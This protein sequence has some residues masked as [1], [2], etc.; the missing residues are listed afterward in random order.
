VKTIVTVFR[1]P[2]GGAAAVA[3]GAPQNPHSRKRSGFS[4]PQEEQIATR[5]V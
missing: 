2:S 5:R 4:S 1:R 3:S